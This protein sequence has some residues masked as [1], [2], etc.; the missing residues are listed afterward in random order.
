MGNLGG[1]SMFHL[2]GFPHC[3]AEDTGGLS[4]LS[5]ILGM[6]LH[7]W[8]AQAWS[9]LNTDSS[10]SNPD[11]HIFT[12]RR[13]LSSNG[14]HSWFGA[15]VSTG[16]NKKKWHRKK[17]KNF[18]NT[19][20]FPHSFFL[21][22]FLL[23]SIG[24]NLKSGFLAESWKW[25]LFKYKTIHCTL[26]RGQKDLEAKGEVRGHLIQPLSLGMRNLEAS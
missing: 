23:P 10:S 6:G 1:N 17:N 12:Q 15:V 20:C 26:V 9:Y 16:R 2:T 3:E 4:V 25:L 19:A 11:L 18:Y 7:A 21:F 24:F 8:E 5:F 22:L 14:I 13:V